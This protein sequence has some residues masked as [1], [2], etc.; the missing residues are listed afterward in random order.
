MPPLPLEPR[1]Y[2][3]ASPRCFH[4]AFDLSYAAAIF[5]PPRQM[6]SMLLF[7]LLLFR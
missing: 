5:M 7:L 4:D 1:H 6:L 2:F 3:A